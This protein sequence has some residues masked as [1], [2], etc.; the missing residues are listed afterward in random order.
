VALAIKIRAHLLDLKIGHIAH[1]AT[2]RAFMA[3]LAAELES[4]D[5]ASLRQHLLGRIDQLGQ[6]H[7]LRKHAGDVRTVGDPDDGL[8]L[9]RLDVAS[10]VN[11]EQLRMQRSL[12]Q[13]KDQLTY[14][15]ICSL[16]F[17]ILCVTP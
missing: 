10:C 1:A 17:H 3:A 6:T 4:F 7:I 5:Q 11:R 12:I 13:R 14:C 16:R 9:L 15:Y 2:E 8:I